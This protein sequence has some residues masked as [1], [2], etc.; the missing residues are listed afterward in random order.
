MSDV[1]EMNRPPRLGSRAVR[2]ELGLMAFSPAMALLAFRAREDPVWLLTFGAPA[3][4]G[5]CVAIVAAVLTKRGSAEPFAFDT[6]DDASDEVIGH[7]GSYLLPAVVDVGQSAEQAVIAAIAL[8]LI[9]QIHIATGRVHLNPLLYLLGYR[10]YR[11]TTTTG[12]A[13]YL[14]ARSDVSRWDGSR[15]LVPLGASLLIERPRD[16]KPET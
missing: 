8:G 11:A 14:L 1:G 7:V 5:V 10:I 3:V 16:A 4:I 13:Y 2:V 15:L 6:I 9:V 12:V